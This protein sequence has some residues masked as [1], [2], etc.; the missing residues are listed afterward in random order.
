MIAMP[1]VNVLIALAM[2]HGG[3]LATLDAGLKSLPPT[4]QQ[5]PAYVIPV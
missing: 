1:D 2:Q 5:Q 4:D 3:Q